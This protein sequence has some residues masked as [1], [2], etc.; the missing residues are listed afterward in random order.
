MQRY[1]LTVGDKNPIMFNDML[2]ECGWAESGLQL[3]GTSPKV[4][5][6]SPEWLWTTYCL[7]VHN[8][9]CD[10]LW[11]SKVDSKSEATFVIME[12]HL[13]SKDFFEK[14]L[15]LTKFIQIS[16]E[17]H[18]LLL[19][20]RL[21]LCPSHAFMSFF[22]FPQCCLS[23][24]GEWAFTPFTYFMLAKMQHWNIFL[25]SSIEVFVRPKDV[26]GDEQCELYC[27]M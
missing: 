15:Y 10:C 20:A 18:E 23:F 27:V 5:L 17:L 14:L 25:N 19:T 13:K 22:R 12:G 24:P 16:E 3:R 8:F 7:R 11:V 4:C 6:P 1:F 26:V 2:C 21:A 9:I